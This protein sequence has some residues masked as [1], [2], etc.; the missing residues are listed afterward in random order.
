MKLSPWIDVDHCSTRVLLGTDPQLVGNRVAFIEK[1]PRVRLSKDKYALET[2]NVIGCREATH[3][4]WIYG[5][6]GSGEFCGRYQPSRD[7]CDGMLTLLG[8]EM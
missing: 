2:P 3:D 8:Y 1:S 5:P 7:W 4:G 6:K